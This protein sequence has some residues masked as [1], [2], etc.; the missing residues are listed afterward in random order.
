MSVADSTPATPRCKPAKPYTEFPLFA[1]ASGQWCKKVCGRFV[2]FGPWDDPDAALAKYLAE[3]DALHAGRKPRPEAGAVT[4]KDACNAFLNHKQTL[5]DA[6]WLSSLTWLKYK[7]VTDLL[8]ARL[9]KTPLVGDLGPDDFAAIHRW[10]T[11]RWGALRV[12]DFIQHIRSVFKHALE[13]EL[14]EKPVRFGPGF[15]RPSRKTMRLERAARGT[16]MFE[17]EEIRRMLDAAGQP[18][19][20]MLLLGV[21]GALGNSDI[22]KLP[23]SA[24]DLN[25]GWVNYPRPKTG[26]PRRAFLWPETIQ[27]VKEVIAQRPEP[28]DPADA[29]LLFI[30]KYGGNWSKEGASRSLTHEMRKLLDKLGI[31]GHRNFYCLRHTH[32][33]V[34]GETK[35]QGAVDHILGH[36]P[37]DM[38]I[39]YR[40]RISDAR[41]KAVAAFVHTWLF[42][43]SSEETPAGDEP[44]ILKI[45]SA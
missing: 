29:E 6:G 44:R 30:T 21:N 1:H 10:M 34:G 45:E 5:L 7:E 25:G 9:G 3:K 43:E 13:S 26:I 40:E 38:A 8:I 11:T 24:L 42:A 14:I 36:A 35:D 41:L 22:G 37:D 28:K 32:E 19:K 20:T 23:L 15:A 39:G 12:R 17:A 2:Y 18:L 4:L 33:T 27:A 16:K 31:D